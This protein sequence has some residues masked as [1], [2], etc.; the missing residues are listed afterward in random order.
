MPG[1]L[2]LGIDL[3]GVEPVATLLN[4]GQ[5]T[6]HVVSVPIEV[7][8]FDRSGR[9]QRLPSQT[10]FPGSTS[11]FA[12]ELAPGAHLAISPAEFQALPFCG[13]VGTPYTAVVRALGQTV[14]KSVRC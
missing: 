2:R 10:E 7:R 8:V 4:T 12:G 5:A 3:F 11:V 14:R 1:D 9:R 6:C 13:G